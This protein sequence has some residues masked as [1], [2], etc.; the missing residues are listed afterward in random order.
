M[1]HL[2]ILVANLSSANFSE[3]TGRIWLS[4]VQCTGNERVLTNCTAMFNAT[5][6]CTHAE[7]VA[8]QCTTGKGE[9]NCPDPR[10]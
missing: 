1:I 6:S 9:K 3:G 5:E 10:N 7:D 2:P 4:N 8:V